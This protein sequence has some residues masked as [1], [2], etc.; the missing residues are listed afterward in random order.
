MLPQSLLYVCDRLSGYSVGCF[1]LEPV[2]S[3]DSS[4]NQT[5]SFDL[6]SNS[7]VIL[8]S[9]RV[10]FKATL[11]GTVARLPA[12]IHSLIE[13][14]EVKAGGTTLSQGANFHNVLLK[15][16]QAVCEHHGDPLSHS[17][18]V[19]AKSYFDGA[20]ITSTNPEVPSKK[21]CWNDW[22]NTFLGTVEPTFFDTS[23]VPDLR[24][25][26]TLATNAV[27]SSSESSAIGVLSTPTNFVKSSAT[28]N[29]SY[30]LS[31]LS[32]NI[33]C[34]SFADN[35][36]DNMVSGLMSRSEYLEV[37][38]KSIRSFLDLHTGSTRFYVATQSLDRIWVAFRASTYSTQG[39]PVPIAGYKQA[40]AFV[41]GSSGGSPTVEVGL[42][43]YDTG[44]VLDTNAEKYVGKF[45][46]Y[47]APNSGAITAQVQLN[48]A[49][50]PQYT[51]TPEEWLEITKHSLPKDMKKDLT[52]DQYLKN[53]FVMCVRLNFPDS[54]KMR[55][56]S[57]LDTRSVN[58]NGSVITSGAGSS[59]YASI[60]AE[61]TST[62]RI[63]KGR[64]IEVIS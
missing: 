53:Y 50:Y 42:P 25:V 24:V 37:P 47:E 54:E 64:T 13:K 44:G 1:R 3:T 43:Q 61:I 41:A 19:R 52:L 28:P 29:A 36:Y 35:T 57:G 34:V 20:T 7:V 27:L 49:Y 55:T 21:L 51:A 14:V 18:I 58:L 33:E 8:K 22:S 15:A 16:Q 2:G 39:A 10:F 4:Q 9:F 11:T 56:I 63:G 30:S 48:G 62:L 45:F 46:N 5:I 12:D 59:H 31:E 23:I 26:I 38:F 60:F 32:A 17:E 40:G 6:P